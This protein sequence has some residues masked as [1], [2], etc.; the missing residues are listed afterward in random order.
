M[1][2]GST[3]NLNLRAVTGHCDRMGTLVYD[4]PVNSDNHAKYE[5]GDESAGDGDKGAKFSCDI[6]GIF[7]EIISLTF[8][9]IHNQ[10]HGRFQGKT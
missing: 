6:E 2:S 9:Q 1:I 4:Q 5:D 10:S 3:K 7:Q 8:M